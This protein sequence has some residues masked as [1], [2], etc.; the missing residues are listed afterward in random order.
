[1][2]VAIEGTPVQVGDVVGASSYTAETTGSN[3][4]VLGIF[5]TEFTASAA[6]T[7]VDLG[8]VSFVEAQ[9][10]VGRGDTFIWAGF[11]L[12]ANIPTG[13]QTITVTDNGTPDGDQYLGLM[14]TLSG[15]D[16]TTP[17]PAGR[18]AGEDV[19]VGV[20]PW[21]VDGVTSL[22]N[23]A[24]FAAI[25]NNTSMS[26]VSLTWTGSTFRQGDLDDSIGAFSI[27]MADKLVS[28]GAAESASFDMAGVER[29]A[30]VM[31]AVAAATAAG[32][33]YY[34]YAQQ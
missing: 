19:D 32:N 28:S 17:L 26:I 13:S 12:D 25:C 5:C 14:Y 9:T 7:G 1:M 2:A 24:I 34:Y 31:F 10:Q 11:I 4:I 16:Q 8:S 15:A 6:I 23:D 22:D 21:V 30:E 18:S 27:A 33:P 3:R 29:G 20:D